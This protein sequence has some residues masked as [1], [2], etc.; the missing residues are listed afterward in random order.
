MNEYD[1]RMHQDIRFWWDEN[2]WHR[3]WM[4]LDDSLMELATDPHSELMDQ[5]AFMSRYIWHVQ[6]YLDRTGPYE[7]PIYDEKEAQIRHMQTFD[8]AGYQADADL[9]YL[10][11]E[12]VVFLRGMMH[13]ELENPMF[14]FKCVQYGLKHAPQDFCAKLTALGLQPVPDWVAPPAGIQY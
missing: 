11:N 7:M 8:I 12:P 9:S 10:G 13:K 1:A 2:L 14:K 3:L 4:Q 6:S 5:T